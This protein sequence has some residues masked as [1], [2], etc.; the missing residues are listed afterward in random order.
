MGLHATEAGPRYGSPV[1]LVDQDTGD[2]TTA[3]WAVPHGVSFQ[4]VGA[5]IALSPAHW[6]A[7]SKTVESSRRKRRVVAGTSV[8]V[9][10]CVLWLFI[11]AAGDNALCGES[12][13]R[14]QAFVATEDG[15][16]IAQERGR[17]KVDILAGRL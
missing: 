9:A 16:E 4:K 5:S 14:A 13:I 10:V 12:D 1:F 11:G 3:R 6:L 17:E 2:M 8:P 15:R 7:E